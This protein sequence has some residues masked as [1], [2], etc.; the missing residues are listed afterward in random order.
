MANWTREQETAITLKDKSLLVSAA[1]GAGKTAVLVERIIRRILDPEKPVDV[2]RILVV[3][4]TNAAAHEMKER[5]AREL[6]A[7]NREFPQDRNLQRQLLL[8]GRAAISTLHSF[9]LELI[10]QNYFLLTL[11]EGLALDP[12]FRI[13]DDTEAVLLKMEVLDNIFEDK[14]NEEDAGFLKLVDCFGGEREDKILQDLV[15]NLY[16]YSRSHPKPSQ[17]LEKV[18]LA[19]HAKLEDNSIQ[20]MFLNLKDSIILPLEEAIINLGE[21]ELL[22]SGRGGP[23]VYVDSLRLEKDL[24]QQTLTMFVGADQGA[25]WQHLLNSLGE[26]KFT[27]LKPCRDID[28][29]DDIKKDVTDLRNGAK[30]IVKKLQKEFCARTPQ[31]FLEDMRQMYPL[32]E[33][34]CVLVKDFAQEYLKVKLQQNKVD[35]ADLEHFALDLLRNTKSGPSETF[36]LAKRLRERYIEVMID[37]YQDIN[38]VQE[39]ILQLVGRESEEANIFMVGDVKQSIYRFRLADP[40]LFMAKY[41]QYAEYGK[42]DRSRTNKIILARN[43]RSR[44]NIVNGVNFVFRQV[45]GARLGGITYNSDAELVYG[46][47]YPPADEDTTFQTAAIEVHLIERKKEIGEPSD[48][49][50]MED[51][52]DN[53]GEDL[54]AQQLEA[55]LTG[56]LLSQ[57]MEKQIWDK[58]VGSYRSV[59]YSDIVILLRS[60]KS[61]APLFLEEFRQV[62]IPAYAEVGTGYLEAQEVQIILA[63]LKVIDNPHQDIPLVAV[64]RSPLIGLTAEELA[65]L[66]GYRTKGCFYNALRLTARCDRGRLGQEMKAFLKRL[67]YW[68]TFSRR[69]SLVELVWLLFRQ[70]GYY[71]YAGALPG[72]RQRQANL[73]AL[74]DR[75]KQYEATAMKGLF[76]FLRFL[77]KLEEKNQDFGTAR[78]LGEKENVVRIMSIH[79]SKGLEFPI[80]VLAGL[81]KLFNQQDLREDILIDKDL[82]LGPVWV[83]YKKR[84]KYPTLARIAVKNKLKRELLAEEIRILY[85][86]MTRARE[87]LFMVGAIKD[88]SKKIKKWQYVASL[89]EWELPTGLLGSATCLWDWLGPCLIRHSSGQAILDLVESKVVPVKVMG[90]DASLWNINFWDSLSLLKS[91]EKGQEEQEKSLAQIVALLPLEEKGEYHELVEYRLGWQYPHLHI[92]DIPAKLS[93]TEIKHRLQRG[94]QDESSSQSFSSWREFSA[95]P[96]FLQEERGL[97][98]E[99]RGSAFHLIMR[100]LDLSA[101]LTGENIKEQVEQMIEK[102]I[103]SPA[104]GESVSNQ[105]IAAFFQTSLGERLKNGSEVMREV[106]FTILLPAAQVLGKQGVYEQEKIL[107]QGTIDCIFAEE[108]GY[109]LLDYKTDYVTKEKLYILKERYQ[110]QMDLYSLAV[111]EILQKP[112]KEKLLYSFTIG[113]VVDLGKRLA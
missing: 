83:D 4:F 32:M 57:L 34:L 50:D 11:P 76:K 102:E 10:R 51:N 48:A 3:T 49:D 41:E 97:S 74:H 89:Q 28:V 77:E 22:A 24:L 43:F 75:A 61:C 112:V 7:R 42:D 85:V 95:R 56:K 93:V 67:R 87:A 86:A 2:D 106:P 63:L 31:E 62:G 44:E 92:A 108:D 36:S 16:E 55:R 65:E 113:E 82:G 17:W 21:A 73:R 100:H 96:K 20:N 88:I 94:S 72:G 27:K 52:E 69:H 37:E 47:G 25:P 90:E 99:E 101:S 40:G 98:S 78:P 29:D 91:A 18:T 70:T 110:V 79:K 26:L 12:R 105:D 45:M 9:C 80:V 81:G 60:V 5:I 109:V 23:S 35:F 59:Q 46:A 33:A 38:N 19:F 58:E 107:V 53:D 13:C 15:L 30:E 14:Y 39:A 8:L 84:L 66:R 54:D 6:M 111:E 71:D 103:I 64:L 104:Q 68:R 1:A